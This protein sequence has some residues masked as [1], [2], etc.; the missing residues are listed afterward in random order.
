MKASHQRNKIGGTEIG[1][2]GSWPSG[3][4]SDLDGAAAA[5]P[6]KLTVKYRKTKGVI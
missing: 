2:V 1:R 6:P 4:Q 3:A 5:E